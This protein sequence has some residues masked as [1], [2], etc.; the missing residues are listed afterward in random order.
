MALSKEELV[1]QKRMKEE[2]KETQMATAK[3]KKQKMLHIENEKKRL[4]PPTDLELEKQAENDYIRERVRFYRM[5][6]GVLMCFY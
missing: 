6:K 4:V 1:Q 2:Q 5:N 3:A